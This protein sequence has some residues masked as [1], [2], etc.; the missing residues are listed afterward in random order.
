M[1]NMTPFKNQKQEVSNVN[2]FFDI[3][4]QMENMIFNSLQSN[5]MP[6]NN[7]S[8][9]DQGSQYVFTLTLPNLKRENIQLIV[10]DQILILTIKQEYQDVQDN[11]QSYQSSAFSQTF[12]LS[13][14]E[15][16][17]I[18]AKLDQDTL[19][20]T[21]PKKETMVVNRRIINVL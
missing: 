16:S 19:T 4:N 18:Y 20:I 1:F 3:F 11:S 9:V 7:T 15:S 2:S 13:D 10:E 17:Q 21:L 14:V 6:M 8:F 5:F 12:N